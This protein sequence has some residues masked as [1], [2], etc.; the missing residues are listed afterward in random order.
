MDK[1]KDSEISVAV[2]VVTFNRKVVVAECIESLLNQSR[3]PDRI[4]VID[5]ASTDGTRES[6]QEKGLLSH[7]EYVRMDE[8]VGGAGGFSAGMA[9][10]FQRGYRWV[11]VMDDDAEPL[12]TTLEELLPWTTSANVV[13]ICP[14]IGDADRRLDFLQ[15]QRGWANSFCNGHIVRPVKPAD[16]A[17]RT[18]VEISHCSFVGLMVSAAAIEKIG[19][20][21]KDFFIHNDDTEYCLRL[22]KLGKIV[23][24]VNSVIRHKLVTKNDQTAEKRFFGRSVKRDKF[25]NLWIQY[26]GHRN[27]SWIV[28]GENGTSVNA[29]KFT[30][31]HLRKLAGVVAYDDHKVQR[32]RFWNAA[33]LDGIRGIFDNEKPKRLTSTKGF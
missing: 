19:L 13:A 18:A 33:F 29:L 24:V 30:F 15:L 23:L 20:P 27:M 31:W 14:A 17:N 9:I 2:V 25:A 26:Y 3:L 5:N 7:V 10:A 8:N 4:F 16:V 22:A 1:Q 11:W 28:F 21:R 32:L 12:R 6:L